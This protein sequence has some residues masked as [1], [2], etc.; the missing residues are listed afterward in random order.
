VDSADSNGRTCGIDVLEDSKMY[1]RREWRTTLLIAAVGLH[2]G[3][4][5]QNSERLQSALLH[6]SIRVGQA[7]G[8]R[9]FLEPLSGSRAPNNDPK[10]LLGRQTNLVD[11]KKNY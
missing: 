9:P 8:D 7:Q 6:S 11:R 10:K 3:T 5:I 1:R 4:V 2:V